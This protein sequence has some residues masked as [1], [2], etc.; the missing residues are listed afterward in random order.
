MSTGTKDLIVELG[1]EEIPAG[2]FAPAMEFLEEKL[3]L[4]LREAHLPFER[5]QTWGAPRRL[6]L[7]LW[8]LAAQQPDVEEEV[9]GPPLSAAYDANGNPTRAA[10]G[11][12]GGQGVSVSDLKTVTTPKGQY[13]AVKKCVKGRAVG[14]ILAEILPGLFAALPFPKNMR[15]GTGEHT[16]VRPV[17]WLLAV[18]DGEV[19]P[20]GFCGAKAGKVSYG[21]RFLHPGALVVTSPH[22]YETRLA[23]SHVQVDFEKRRELVR[24]EIERVTREHSAD[25]RL[26]ADEEL[27][28]EVANLLEEPV[29]VLG[30]FD[31]HFLELPLAVATTAMKEHQRYFALTDSKGRLAPYFIAVNN[32]RARDMAVVRKGHE[33]V[34]R[35]R[36]DDARFY[37]DEDRKNR[38]DSRIEALKG[39]VFHHLM[40]TSWQK[41]ERFKALALHLAEL[42][43][44]S[45][46][47]KLSR[48]ADL[49]KCD[50]VTGVVQ[51][52]PSLQGLMGREYALLDG[53]DPAVAEAVFEHYLPARAGGALPSAPLGAILSVADKLD[54]IA[55]CFSVGLIPSGAADPFALRRG[56][57]GIL[58]IFLDRGWAVSLSA[59]IDQSLELLAPWAKRPPRE[60]KAAVAEFFKVRL[61]GLMTGR[62]LSADTAEAVLSLHDDQPVSALRRAQALEGLKTREGFKDLAQVFKR[63]V[64]IIRKF[65]PKDEFDDWARLEGEA[66]KALLS[67]VEK[68][69]RLSASQIQAGDFTGLINDIA[70][71]R[72]PVDKFFEQALVDDPDPRLKAARIALLSRLGRLFELIA[73][74]SRLSAA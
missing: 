14:E 53:E 65:G 68:V 54:T 9:V 43:A 64:N 1:V 16:F 46:K 51:E 57:L 3:T 42:A 12:A 19:L 13:L 45:Q 37:F 49:C 22:E 26:V 59:L 55:G 36:L 67:R 50:L 72:G 28:E 24:Q 69:E 70:D 74:F 61:K 63:V 27:V 32:N 23:E 48:A 58:N 44:P 17:H 56:A 33:R 71:L 60:T 41:V 62:G 4:A 6:A 15:W 5:L 20:F 38:L 52:F 2:Y 18:L 31:S 30:R 25:L 47:I 29:A 34:L 73:D 66:E 7:G 39:V 21:H 35:A 11:F 8:G 10:T 40:G